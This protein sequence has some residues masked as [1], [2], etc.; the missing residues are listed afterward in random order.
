MRVVL[1]NK[2]NQVAASNANKTGHGG[3]FTLIELLVVIAIIAILA[4]IL[5]PVLARAKLKATEANCLSNQ[6]QIGTSWLMYADD[7]KENLLES[8]YTSG[9]NLNQCIWFQQPGFEDGGGFWG[10]NAGFTTTSQG[11]AMTNVLDCLQNDNLLG[12]YAANP[13]VFH[14]PGDVRFNRPI[15]NGWAYDSYAVPENVES[16]GSSDNNSF[17]AIAAIKKPASCIIMV[18]QA[19][20]RGYNKGTFAIDTTRTSAGLEDV[21]SMYHGNVGTFAFADGHAE[22]HTWHNPYIIF[23]GK[24]SVNQGPSLGY[25]YNTCPFTASQCEGVAGPLND[26]GWI[27]QNFE[28][29]TDL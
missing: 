26:I 11:A 8:Y 13:Q 24:Y 6:K 28:S 9:P 15:G 12:P 5:L 7:N 23:D 2:G 29:P 1:K 4:A 3:G 17:S 22:A 21:F 27:I 19:D 18:E 14:C 16:A 25:E 20:P 10:M